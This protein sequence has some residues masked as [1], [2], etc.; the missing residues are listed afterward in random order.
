LL[1]GSDVVNR[2]AREQVGI[3]RIKASETFVT[4]M[5]EALDLFEEFFELIE[6]TEL[7]VFFDCF[8]IIVF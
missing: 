4:G 3:E 6:M 1:L 5:Y 7:S 8:G 2:G